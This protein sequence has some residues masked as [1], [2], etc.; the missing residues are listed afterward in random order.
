M[1]K[2][3]STENSVVISYISIAFSILS[4]LIYTPWLIKQLGQSDY[5]IYSIAIAI[6]SYFTI[7]FGIGASITRFIARYRSEGHEEKINKLLGIALKLYIV[8]DIVALSILS[9][10]FFFLQDIYVG[11]TVA[12]LERLQVVFVITAL[13]II[14]CIPALPTNGVYIAFGRVFDVKKFDLLQKIFTVAFVCL[15]IF[16][17]MGLYAVTMINAVVTVGLNI[18]KMLLIHKTERVAPDLRERNKSLTKELF[19]FSIW[20][21][22]AMIADKFFFAAEPSL[23]GMFSNSTEVAVFAVAASLEGYVLL[24]SDGLNG[25]FLPRV[26]DMVVKKKSASEI[27][28]LMIKVGRVQLIIISLFILGIFT[29]GYDFIR[30]WFGAE[31]EKSFFAAV[32]ILIPCFIHMTEAIGIEMVYATNNVKYRALAYISGSVVNIIVTAILAPKLGAIGAAIG[33][34]SGFSI[35]HEI[36]LNIV[37]AKILKL[38]LKRFFVSCHLKM[39]LPGIIMTI[40]GVVMARVFPVNGRLGIIVRCVIWALLYIVCIFFMFC[41]KEEKERARLFIKKIAIKGKK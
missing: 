38:E 27:T 28:D 32:I 30:V 40:I 26:T 2:K 41:N 11:L 22:F 13:M 3:Q 7:D 29:Q 34:A 39:L 14:C 33:I 21:A 25:I 31:Y 12:E 18:T 19:A 24:F 8:I 23:L 35:G 20:V 15:A 6:M 9:I 5:A 17:G 36:V 16:C 10:L 37:Y 1:T 4:G